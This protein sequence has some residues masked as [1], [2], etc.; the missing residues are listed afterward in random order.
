MCLMSENIAFSDI[1]TAAEEEPSLNQAEF[2]A[3]ATRAIALTPNVDCSRVE[4][5]AARITHARGELTVRLDETM[6]RRPTS[7]SLSLQAPSAVV[8]L[9]GSI[10]GNP[11][12]VWSVYGNASAERSW[13]VSHGTQ[14]WTVDP[15]GQRRALGG[16]DCC[17]AESLSCVTS[18]SV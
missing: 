14:Y 13:R 16:P 5:R 6:P 11:R 1:K 4:P 9:V 8:S 3:G 12:L 18:G 10:Y 15:T 7:I 17:L 2:A